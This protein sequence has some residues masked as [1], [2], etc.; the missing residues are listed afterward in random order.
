MSDIGAMSQKRLYENNAIAQAV[1]LLK[2][3]FE[4][5]KAALM[6]TEKPLATRNS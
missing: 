4:Y 6:V 1:L 3:L 2:K 5:C